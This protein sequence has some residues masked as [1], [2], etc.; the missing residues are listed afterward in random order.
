MKKK[1]ISCFLAACLLLAGCGTKAGVSVNGRN[2]TPNK[3]SAENTRQNSSGLV[4][5]DW[6]TWG[7]IDGFGTLHI[8]GQDFGMTMPGWKAS[9]QR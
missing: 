4:G 3:P 2:A 1:T 9:L 6:R 5:Q 7:I 8:E